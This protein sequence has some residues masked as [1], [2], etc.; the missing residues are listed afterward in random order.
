MQARTASIT[1]VPN[2]CRAI[3]HA[4]E[5]RPWIAHRLIPVQQPS[6]GKRQKSPFHSSVCQ[7]TTLLSKTPPGNIGYTTSSTRYGVGR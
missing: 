5:V 1:V 7:Q 3:I 6:R 2:F 4:T